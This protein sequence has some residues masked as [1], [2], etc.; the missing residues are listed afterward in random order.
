MLSISILSIGLVALLQWFSQSLNIIRISENY[1]KA[2]MILESKMA[3][4]ELKL[5]EGKSKFWTGDLEE[6]ED[7]GVSFT[8]T[9]SATPVECTKDLES[10]DELTYENLYKVRALLSWRDGKRKGAI[11]VSTYLINYEEKAE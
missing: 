10:G 6:I 7:A 1:L 9:S 3:E 4:T 11:P 2:S 5:K 8:L